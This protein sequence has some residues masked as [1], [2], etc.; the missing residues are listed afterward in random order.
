MHRARFCTP[1]SLRVAVRYDNLN[2]KQLLANHGDMNDTANTIFDKLM[3]RASLDGLDAKRQLEWIG[4]LIDLS[5]DLAREEGNVRALE[6]CD[7]L[8]TLRLT[9]RQKALLEYFRANTW[10]NRQRAAYRNGDEVIWQW[11]QPELEKQIFHLRKASQSAGFGKLAKLRQSQIQTNLANQ[12]SNVGRFIDAI[13]YWDRVLLIRPDFGIALGNRGNGLIAYAQ[14]V[15]DLGHRAVLLLFAHRALEAALSRKARYEQFDR[16]QIKAFFTDRKERVEAAI[17]VKRAKK[18]VKIDEYPIGNS[19]EERRYRAWALQER[20]FLNPLNDLGPHSIA[21]QDVLTLP[22]FTL[23]IGETPSLIG[24]F[25]QMKQ[26]YVSGRWLL[27]EGLHSEGVHFSDRRTMIMNTL[28]YT[29]H[30]LAIEKVKAAF[31][32]GYSIL[33]KIA[34]FLNNYMSL[35]IE[36]N[37]I[38]FKSIWYDRKTRAVRDE[39]TASRNW[40]MRGLYWLTK[41]LF[42]PEL[43]DVMEPDAQALWDIRNCL[44]H[45]YLKVHEFVVPPSG[46]AIV[47]IWNDELAYSVQRSDFEA[48]TLRVFRLARSAMIYLS[49]AMHEEER[50]RQQAS[51]PGKGPWP[52]SLGVME[53]DW[54]R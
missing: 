4:T 7:G 26:E 15:Y 12:L 44:E 22:D 17:D 23:K 16:E 30:S 5:G 13:A 3:M 10:A 18:S 53:D 47:D 51:P 50:R 37:R 35:G 49:S 48:K 40:P 34:F 28:D 27:Y 1:F 52:M 25:N 21:A 54:K 36:P 2:L 31:R 24:F 6:W 42:D 8:E 9:D 39:F 33:D 11:V 38:Y 45:R 29:G 32:I 14:S 46:N 20:L 19:A 41:D 43:Q